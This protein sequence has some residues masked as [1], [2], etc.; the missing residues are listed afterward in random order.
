MGV[1]KNNAPLVRSIRDKCRVC[2][3]CVRECPVKAIKI[4][5]GQAEVIPT[6]CVGCGNCVVVCTRGAKQYRSSVD[7]VIELLET[8]DNVVALVAPSFPAEFDEVD[9][10]EEHRQFVGMLR[11]LGFSKVCEVAFGADLV[12]NEY[13]KFL[14][15][16]IDE[17][18]ISSPCPSITSYITKYFPELTNNLAKVVSPMIAMAMVVKEK[19][20]KDIKTVFIGPCIAKKSEAEEYDELIDKVLTFTELKD[21]FEKKEITKADV[22]PSEFD[23]P[24]GGK[25]AVFP[26]SGGLLQTAD[27]YENLVSGKVIV[28]EGRFNFPEAIKE[29]ESGQLMERHLDLLCCDGCIMGPGMSKGGKQFVRRSLV[30]RYVQH[31]L[32]S[33]NQDE[34]KA[35]LAKYSHLDYSRRFEENDTRILVATDDEVIDILS[36]MGKTKPEDE[37]NCQAC[38]YDSCREHAIAIL[39]GLAE[40]EMCLPYTIEKMHDYI[41]DLA[42][43]N[44]NLASTREALKQSEKLA[45]MGQ[46]S[47]GIAHEVNNPLGVV[48]LYSNLL[49]EETNPNSETYTDL[50]MIATQADRCKN[51]LSGLLNFARKNKV[52]K[53]Q[54]NLVDLIS[55]AI[56]DVVVPIG[57]NVNVDHKESNHTL[58]IDPDQIRQVLSNLIKNAIEAMGENKGEVNVTTDGDD[59][60]VV[61]VV[62]D[63]GPGVPK[64]NL[65]KLFEPFF[66]TKG[67][68]K[69]TGLG[70]SVSYG[71]IKMH[72][73]QI[74]V[75]SNND[76][77]AGPTWTRFKITLPRNHSE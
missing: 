33:I 20:G 70:L 53:K 17:Y 4:V 1:E 58:Y 76:S 16:E 71:I 10:V 28:A 41:T 47:A 26:L 67:V 69:G 54:V 8:N 34:L 60:N 9:G 29:F 42:E 77:A 35:E 24:L 13:R 43:S 63:N 11:K 5:N 38:G 57:V 36:K 46:L 45:S 32:N 39:K 55:T 50:K 22:E 44:R 64:D 14:R 27:M 25:G 49:L 23:P 21:I 74:K 52:V 12:A 37:L 72:K 2:Y 56:K 48:L 65:D 6:R 51:I 18:L 7:S 19:Y 15:D 73:G 61:I 75:E 30:S 66:T 59:N 31:K 68:G 62:E 40:P 3:T